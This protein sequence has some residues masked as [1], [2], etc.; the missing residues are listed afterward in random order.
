[1]KLF[2]NAKTKIISKI[3]VMQNIHPIERLV[4]NKKESKIS[5]ELQI[6]K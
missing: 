6:S 4:N 1:L 5:R 3:E 2:E